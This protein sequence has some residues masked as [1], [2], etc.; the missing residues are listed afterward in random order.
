VVAAACEL[1]G[2]QAMSCTT[3]IVTVTRR[4]RE[5]ADA[6]A[7]E[8]AADAHDEVGERNSS[9]TRLPVVLTKRKRRASPHPF[10]RADLSVPEIQRGDVLVNLRAVIQSVDMR[11]GTRG[12]LLF[13]VFFGCYFAH[14]SQVRPPGCERAALGA[15]RLAWR[16]KLERSGASRD[17]EH[18]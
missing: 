13:S 7:A 6:E 18:A 9:P 14:I 10:A 12:L 11:E 2:E 1:P 15:A 5:R 4:D 16:G 3:A 17:W 8:A